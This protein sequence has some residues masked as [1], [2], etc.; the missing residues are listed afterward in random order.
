MDQLY[1]RESLS[2]LMTDGRATSFEAVELAPLRGVPG[3]P[4]FLT[5]ST[6]PH[7][8]CASKPAKIIPRS[9]NLMQLIVIECA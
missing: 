2:N 8:N 3:T 7:P 1:I 4:S 6:V 9:K 5:G